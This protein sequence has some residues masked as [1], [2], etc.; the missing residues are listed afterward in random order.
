[1]ECIREGEKKTVMDS[2]LVDTRERSSIYINEMDL[3][4]YMR[5]LK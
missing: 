5:A 2:R 4:G 3:Y 1:M